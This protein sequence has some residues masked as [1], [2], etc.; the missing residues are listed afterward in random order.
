MNLPTRTRDIIQMLCVK[1]K[2]DSAI[3]V[4]AEVSTIT[5]TDR[6]I[7]CH[8]FWLDGVIGWYVAQDG[9]FCEGEH[10]AMESYIRARDNLIACL[11]RA[12]GLD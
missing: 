8:L 10:D 3:D 6:A 1:G 7:W 2:F 11:D 9:H 4:N 5:E 12:W